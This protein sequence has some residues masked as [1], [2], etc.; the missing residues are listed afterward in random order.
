MTER[1]LVRISCPVGCRL[2]VSIDGGKVVNVT[3]NTCPRGVAYAED[4][5]IDPKRT[6]TTLVRVEGRR[7]PLPVKTSSPIPKA[8]IMDCV[9]EAKKVIAKA[10]VAIGDV[11]VKN[12]AGTDAD[13]I[14]TDILS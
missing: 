9:A 11:L 3:G 5:C 7:E 14:A 2:T 13:L 4:E 6:V 1:Q 8:R 10:P 12:V